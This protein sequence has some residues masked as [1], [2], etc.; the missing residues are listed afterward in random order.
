M[1]Q[2][3][4]RLSAL[5][6]VRNPEVQVICFLAMTENFE[7]MTKQQIEKEITVRKA[8]APANARI[9]PMTCLAPSDPTW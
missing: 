2:L 8:N 9:V 5:E 6:A 4:K 3:G 7:P 1:S